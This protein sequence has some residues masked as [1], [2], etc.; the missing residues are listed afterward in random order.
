MREGC[1]IGCLGL[2]AVTM[3]IAIVAV[4]ALDGFFGLFREA[5]R[6][7]LTEYYGQDHDLMMLVE[8][9][10]DLI[11]SAVAEATDGP[12]WF[13]DY[14]LP[15][16]V[17][18]FIDVDR[19]TMTN[20]YTVAAS[21]KRMA[22]FMSYYLPRGKGFTI[23]ND[24]EITDLGVNSSGVTYIEAK[25]GISEET[26]DRAVSMQF[27][28]ASELYQIE[29]GHLAQIVL[30]NTGGD[31]FVA[32]QEFFNGAADNSASGDLLTPEEEMLLGHNVAAAMLVF[33][34][35][36]SDTVSLH[37]R[38]RLTEPENATEVIPLLDEAIRQMA[39]NEDGNVTIDGG[40]RQESDEVVGDYTLEHVRDRIG[41]R[42]EESFD[43]FE[44]QMEQRFEN[45]DR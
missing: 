27:I 29:S 41:A 34:T 37:V 23:F 32:L 28:E 17:T 19:E 24:A 3:I 31:A 33:D 10:F 30:N 38:A 15:Y 40:F 5:D 18:L 14:V 1:L 13:I 43:E 44:R 11:G 21:L 45:A 6:V 4:V 39:Q 2:I 8:P 22:G 9:N 7:S 16:E 12:A 35:V 25:S 26:A 36:N 42:W 20:T